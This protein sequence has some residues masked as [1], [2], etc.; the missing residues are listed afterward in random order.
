[1]RRVHIIY[2]G[3]VTDDGERITLGGVQTYLLNLTKVFH[4]LGFEIHF[5]K[6]ADI[7]K[8]NYLS[9]LFVHLI[10]TSIPKRFPILRIK[11]VFRR[12]KERI[13][14]DSDLVLFADDLF[15]CRARGYRTISIQHG[16]FWDVPQEMIIGKVRFAWVYFRK[17]LNSIQR[18]IH[19]TFSTIQVCVDYNYV[20]WYR[21]LMPYSISKLIVIPNF[22]ELLP[23]IEKPTDYINIVFARRFEKMRGTRIFADAIFRVLNE[24]KNVKV[25]LAGWGSDEQWL[26]SKL[27]V[28]PNVEFTTYKSE[29]SLAFHSR[30]HI[31][32]VPTIGSEGTSLSLLE[33]MSAQCAVI[34]S[35]VGGITNILIDG[36]NGLMVP[37]GDSEALYKALIQLITNPEL[38]LQL[39]EAGY[40]TVKTG[41]SIDKWRDK[42]IESINKAYEGNSL[43]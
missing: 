31:A 28:Y 8:D 24:Y 32:V 4:D 42:W 15:S 26:R 16:I 41:F 40:H 19:S 17:Q 21:S 13:N 20:N 10:R 6:P 9:G 38:R 12:M 43:R 23:K 37:S 2:T 5:Y 30:F 35:D 18:L 27:E 3:F 22:T 39:S 11:T 33:A 7:N 36:F 25:T 34:G 1:M 29:E 14:K